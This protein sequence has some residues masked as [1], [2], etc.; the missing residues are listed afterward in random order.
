MTKREKNIEIYQDT[1]EYSELIDLKP[2]TEKYTF[3]DIKKKPLKGQTISLVK[4]DT[5]SL[6]Q[7]LKGKGKTCVLNMASYKR[8]GGG[9]LKGS[10]AQEECLYRSSNLPINEDVI[11]YYPLANDEAL[12]VKDVTFFKDYHYNLMEPI[13]CDVITIAALNL[14]ED[15]QKYDAEI[16]RNKIRLM[17]SLAAKNECDN[18]I[19]GAWGSGVFKNDPVNVA[20]MFKE[21]IKHFSIPNIYFAIINDSNS[22]SDNY[23]VYK[24]VLFIKK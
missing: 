2:I 8:P 3:L 21:Q 5:V 9:V 1:V 20:I 11:K 23:N 4:T 24:D 6:L 22:V 18:I 10:V 15:A 16:M 17:L 7:T 12:Y 13:V 14:N 19:L